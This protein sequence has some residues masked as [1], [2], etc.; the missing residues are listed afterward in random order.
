MHHTVTPFAFS[1]FPFC[2]LM[3][4]FSCPSSAD[5]QETPPAQKRRLPP[6]SLF[7]CSLLV[8]FG[9]PF[10][11][12][13]QLTLISPVQRVMVQF[14]NES[15][16]SHYSVRLDR[17]D[18]EAVWGA[19]VASFFAGAIP[20]ALLTQ[21][22]ADNFGRKF[23]IVLSN[24]AIVFCALLLS[25]SKFLNSI[26]L[27]VASRFILGFFVTIGIGISSV[28]LTEC[29][30]VQCRGGIG[31]ITGIMIQFGCIVGAL[32]A[33]PELLVF[34]YSTTSTT[35]PSTPPN[36]TGDKIKVPMPFWTNYVLN[37]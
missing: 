7:L 3:V 29:S 31:M 35:K 11:Y 21:F 2:C 26:E 14:I 8:A 6:I 9:V 18:A 1:L 23:G 30:P 28:F 16:H 22:V 27:F 37:K 13:F 5:A 25:V 10:H 15:V 36:F 24:A 12:G 17:Y 33:M 4:S 34:Y 32:L 20:G 19:T